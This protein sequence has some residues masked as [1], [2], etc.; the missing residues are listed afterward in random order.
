MEFPVSVR[1]K[2][3]PMPARG[4]E[5]MITIGRQGLYNYNNTDHCLDMSMKG[6]E[7]IQHVLDGEAKKDEWP[8]LREYFDNYR[9][10]D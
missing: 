2:N 10:V 6:A 3:A 5:N 1:L 8:K 4:M 7:Y 9:I